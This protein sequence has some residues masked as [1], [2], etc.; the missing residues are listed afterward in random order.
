MTRIALVVA[1][2]AAGTAGTPLWGDTTG[3]GVDMNIS[4]TGSLGEAVR[5]ASEAQAI[6]ACLGIQP[7]HRAGTRCIGRVAE[8]CLKEATADQEACYRRE[9]DGW[10]A[11]VNGYRSQLERRYATDG[12]KLANLQVSQREWQDNFGRRC[13][14]R[15][16]S[17]E[18][19][20]V[21]ASTAACAMRESG[22]RALY[23]RIL[24]KD[25]TL[26]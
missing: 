1:L 24:A 18:D 5:G 7:G 22:R 6:E 3:R 17:A 19:V 23:L 15:P 11:L 20:D 2:L 21:S 9:A 10:A 26:D 8:A 16:T 14:V 25:T 4:V 13:D 12:R